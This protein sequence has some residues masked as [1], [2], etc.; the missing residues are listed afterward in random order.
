MPP[1]P[2]CPSCQS[3]NTQWVQLPGTGQ[4][5]SFAVCT[6][7]PFPDVA[8]FVYAPVVV[9]LDEAP[10]VR[11]VSNL[12]ELAVP[13]IHIGLRVRVGWNPITNGWKLPI[14]RPA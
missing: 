13:D 2:F 8:D 12:V 11:L 3:Q 7:S 6:R 14:F 9:E 10:G 1:T 4:V 5:Y